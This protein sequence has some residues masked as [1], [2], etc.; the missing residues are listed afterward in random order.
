MAPLTNTFIHRLRAAW[1]MPEREI[2]EK[3]RD[4]D[5]WREMRQVD[6]SSLEHPRT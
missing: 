3:A 5:D 1:D 4:V 6:N 2:K